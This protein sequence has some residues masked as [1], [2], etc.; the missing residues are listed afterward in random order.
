MSRLPLRD[1][2]VKTPPEDVVRFWSGWGITL[3]SLLLL[4]AAA[5]LPPFV[6]ADV[7]EA[8]MRGLSIA[9]HQLPDRSPHVHGIALGV[10]HR[11]YGIYW[12]MP[13]AAMLFLALRRWDG[14]LGRSG[15]YLLLASLL[16]PGIDW[17][18]DVLGLWVNTPFSRLATGAVFGLA[19]GYY[20]TR[21]MVELAVQG[22]GKPLA[23]VETEPS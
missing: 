2:D 1:D 8:L 19:A 7:R 5:T 17:L 23:N 13:V 15:G 22:I 4:V 16:P 14:A 3:G 10:C 12:G 18:G 20:L 9:C 21:A 11:C 6:S